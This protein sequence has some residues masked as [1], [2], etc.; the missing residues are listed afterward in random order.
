[1]R[2]IRLVAAAALMLV[3]LTPARAGKITTD[4]NKPGLS[5]AKHP[6]EGDARLDRKITYTATG[7]RLYAILE[8]LSRQSGLIVQCGSSEKDWQTR[9]LPVTVGVVNLPL[10]KLLRGIADCT[11]LALTSSK[12]EGQYHYKMFLD[13][14]RR[15]AIADYYERRREAALASVNWE[16]DAWAKVGKAPDSDLSAAYRKGDVQDWMLDLDGV[17][18]LG[19]IFAALGPAQRKKVFAGETLHLRAKDSSNPSADAVAKLYHG[20]VSRSNPN[21][22]M[23]DDGDLELRIAASDESGMLGIFFSG[24]MGASPFGGGWSLFPDWVAPLVDKAPELPDAGAVLA[25]SYARALVPLTASEDEKDD[26][27]KQPILQA[28]LKLPKPKDWEKM[29]YDDLL[30]QICRAS[31]FSMICEGFPRGS[32]SEETLIDLL[33]KESTLGEALRALHWQGDIEW[34]LDA[35]TRLVVG[36]SGNWC[37]KHRD[38]VPESLIVGLRKKLDGDGV[39]IDDLLPVAALTSGQRSEWIDRTEGFSSLGWRSPGLLWSLYAS[40]S[41]SDKTLAKSAAGFPLAK[42]DPAVV[43]TAFAKAAKAAANDSDQNVWEDNVR[44]ALQANPELMAK[45]AVAGKSFMDAHAAE[46]A[47]LKNKSDSEIRAGAKRLINEMIASIPELK[48]SRQIPTDPNVVAKLTLRVIKADPERTGGSPSSPQTALQKRIGKR[49]Y[50]LEVRGDGV[51][52]YVE[53]P[54]EDLPIYSAEREKKLLD[55]A[56]KAAG[57]DAG[58]AK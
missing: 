25:H 27:A 52:H 20:L 13:E 46:Y 24:G 53:G 18:T 1:M 38:L 30:T 9:D 49:S 44:M 56:R 12:I 42:L 4:P 2:A 55:D 6:V 40:L 45:V 19:S 50:M 33:G 3:A 23:G 43:N 15:T 36:P 41:D 21:A 31:Q 11:H 57:K 34:Y 16:W 10:G 39:G 58:K 14:A 7:K 26:Y 29:K 17:R 8:D 54:D 37:D 35:E 32:I 22:E 47:Q 5:P 28:K 51:R 48:V